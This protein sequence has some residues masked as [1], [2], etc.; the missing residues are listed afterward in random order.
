[1]KNEEIKKLT[2]TALAD[3]IQALEQGR[4]ECLQE[5]LT[6]LARFHS[7]SWGNVL[8]IARQKPQATR[9]AGYR[10]WLRMKRHV[11]KGEKGIVI[12]APIVVRKKETETS[13]DEETRLFGFR[14]AYVFDISQTDGEAL[15]EFA[16]VQGDPGHYTERLFCFADKKGIAVEFS[17]DIG[18]A[19]GISTGGKILLKP[20]LPAAETFA[21]L[22]HE[23][24]HERLHH[25]HRRKQTS[26]CVR[27][28]EAE[29]VAFVVT[30]AVGLETNTAA[31]DYIQLYQGDNTT[32]VES[33]SF[34]QSTAAEILN[35]LLPT[36]ESVTS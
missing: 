31:A 23:L 20:E 2:D 4:S 36:E 8:L 26:K 14:S 16:R 7:Y 35:F 9:V 10:A 34:I 30:H 21:V 25:G 6:T 28:T 22:V 11:K 5:Y 32:L 12:L 27:E 1:M 15:P 17:T 18:T 33:L 13:E 29:A 24:A 19:S 3:L